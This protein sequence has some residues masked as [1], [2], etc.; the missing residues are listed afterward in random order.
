MVRNG[1]FKGC[2]EIPHLSFCILH[3]ATA[4]KESMGANYQILKLSKS[5]NFLKLLVFHQETHKETPVGAHLS[6]LCYNQ[7][8]VWIWEVPHPS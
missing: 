4:A 8:M 5:K 2:L 1:A 6:G 7:M 3:T